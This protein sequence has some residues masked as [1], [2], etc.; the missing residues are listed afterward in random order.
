[1][2]E[3]EP[4]KRRKGWGCLQWGVV[5]LAVCLLG[6]YW[7]PFYGLINP[8][9]NQMKAASN[10]RQITGLLLTYAAD[11][12]GQLPGGLTANAAF[13][14]L[15]QEGLVQDESIFG[16]RWSS[17]IPDK[18]IGSAPDFKQ[19]LEPG[20]NHW[21][22]VEG[23]KNTF[24]PHYPAVMENAQ[25]STWPP[26]WRLP[27]SG[28]MVW[29]REQLNMQL[30]PPPPGSSWRNGTLIV[31]RLNA[32]VEMLKLVEKD[33]RMHLPGSFLKPEGLPPLPAFQLLDVERKNE[34]SSTP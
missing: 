33:G 13:R 18:Q 11:H 3:N 10:A 25:E 30:P 26:S 5:I 8:R 21:A 1:M 31:A 4:E 16:T 2:S 24:P 7:I 32:S 17:L 12:A 28:T 14:K 27:P 15:F 9:A 19:A 20:E 23:H 29:L 22:L 34:T 6:I